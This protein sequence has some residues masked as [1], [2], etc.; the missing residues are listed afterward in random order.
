MQARASLVQNIQAGLWLA[1]MILFAAWLAKARD[2]GAVAFDFPGPLLVTASAC[3][4][5][6]A[7]L[8]LATLLALPA[9]W[10]GGRRVES[11]SAWRKLA[12]SLTVLV[13]SALAA[14]LGLWGA[15]SPWS[16]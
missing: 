7:V 14:T 3:A 11:W 1:A 8:T 4:L 5:V 16:G 6:A 13:Y 12:F 15:L 2:P 9:V 10:Q